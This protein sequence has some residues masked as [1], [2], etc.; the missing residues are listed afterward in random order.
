MTSS[1]L[2]REM[3]NLSARARIL[4][5]RDFPMTDSQELYCLLVQI[6]SPPGSL[7]NGLLDGDHDV[8]GV[9]MHLVGEVSDFLASVSGDQVLA[10]LGFDI[11]PQPSDSDS[12]DLLHT[13]SSMDDG[14]LNGFVDDVNAILEMSAD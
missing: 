6:G 13:V 10:F 12:V 5:H 9:D 4:S 14:L 8:L 11:V 2:L 3:E 1:I 7:C